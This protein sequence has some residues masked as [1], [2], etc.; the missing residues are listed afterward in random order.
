MSNGM[1]GKN[2]NKR[3]GNTFS[4]L[5]KSAIMKCLCTGDQ[6]RWIDE[7]AT[8]GLRRTRRRGPTSGE[9]TE[10]AFNFSVEQTEAT[11]CEASQIDQGVCCF[12]YLSW[13]STS[14][15]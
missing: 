6:L 7:M 4:C 12:F 13:Y 9:V 3:K 11:V 14:R 5:L 10:D 15:R 1:R 8:H 2:I